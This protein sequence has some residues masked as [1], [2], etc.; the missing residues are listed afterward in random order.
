[1]VLCRNGWKTH[2][3]TALIVFGCL[4]I[5][6]LLAYRILDKYMCNVW[7]PEKI[8]YICYFK[9]LSYI[10]ANKIICNVSRAKQIKLEGIK[11]LLSSLN[12]SKLI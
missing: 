2:C 8:I 12:H 11:I 3:G 9:L 6:W 10:S 4:A 5:S 7:L 1:M